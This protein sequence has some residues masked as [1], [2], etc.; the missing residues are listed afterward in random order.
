VVRK[1]GREKD[2]LDCAKIC[3]YLFAVLLHHMSDNY[4]HQSWLYAS[5]E[6]AGRIFKPLRGEGH[7]NSTWCNF[8]DS[9]PEC[10]LSEAST[11]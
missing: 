5:R 2:L 7:G 6:A 4:V 9:K 3:R 8:L 1:G 11:T 10:F